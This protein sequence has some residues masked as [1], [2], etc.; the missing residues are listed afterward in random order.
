MKASE[1][2]VISGGLVTITGIKD[3]NYPVIG[4]TTIG[5]ETYTVVSI[6]TPRCVLVKPD[7]SVHNKVINRNVIM[8]YTFTVSPPDLTFYKSD[9]EK[10]IVDADY[11]NYE[12]I[13][14]GTDGKSITITYREYTKSDLARPAFYQNLVYQSGQSKIRF[15]ETVIEIHEATNE[16]IV[17]TIIDDGLDL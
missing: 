7:G 8:V 14:G 10:K 9:D 16:K 12:L 15:K 17:F 2:F 3:V 5:N 6:I 11:I 13:Y 1:D 4:E